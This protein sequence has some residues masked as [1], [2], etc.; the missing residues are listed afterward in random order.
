MNMYAFGMSIGFY[1]F[2]HFSRIASFVRL[3]F[4]VISYAGNFA[5]AREI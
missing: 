1:L 4:M 3:L 5:G 2:I